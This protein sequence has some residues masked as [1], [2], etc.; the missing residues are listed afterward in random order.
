MTLQV[1]DLGIGRLK[2]QLERL[3][4]LRV[5][6]GVQGKRAEAKHPQAEASVGQVAAWLHFGTAKMVARP[7]AAL[8]VESIKDRAAVVAKR[9]ASDLIDRRAHDEVEALEPLGR[10]GLEAVLD[11]FDQAADWAAPLAPA[12]VARKGH[13][14]PLLDTGTVREANSYTIREGRQILAEG[15]VE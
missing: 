15:G 2:K 10:M 9:A 8:A 12:T 4:N 5:Y 14:Q 1:K 6:V 7:W 13:D 3:G 11:S